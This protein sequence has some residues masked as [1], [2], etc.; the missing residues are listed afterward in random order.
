[1]K[2]P[3]QTTFFNEELKE[4]IASLHGRQAG[5]GCRWVSIGCSIVIL[6]VPYDKRWSSSIFFAIHEVTV[7][8]LVS[9]WFGR[10]VSMSVDFMISAANI[11]CCL[12]VNRCYTENG[13]VHCP[14]GAA[15]VVLQPPD[16]IKV[17]LQGTIG[18]KEVGVYHCLLL[19]NHLLQ[20][21]D[22]KSKRMS[23]KKLELRKRRRK[24]IT[25]YVIFSFS[26]LS[27]SFLSRSK[28]CFYFENLPLVLKFFDTL[29]TL[30]HTP[31]VSVLFSWN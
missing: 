6:A 29:S 2:Y 30:N 19:V 17:A 8:A 23:V 1:M 13:A 26:A 10:R 20:V 14:Q 12:N 21:L 27:I 15:K 9:N 16:D 18:D 31:L 4:V 7:H 22:R 25:V 11:C 3:V 28:L 24:G 5:H